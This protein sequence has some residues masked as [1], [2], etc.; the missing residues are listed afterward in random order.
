M[1][2]L[3]SLLNAADRDELTA[4]LAERV[5]FDRVLAPLTWWQVGGPA[6]AYAD[7]HSE[8]ELGQVLT[9]CRRRSMPY[10]VLGNGSNILVGDGGIRGLVL[11]LGGEFTSIDITTSDTTV[12]VNAGGAASLALL[13][14]QAASRGAVGIDGLAGVPA[15]VGGAVRMNAGTEREIG[16][17]TREVFVQSLGHPEPASVFVEYHYR[18]S[19]LAADAIVSRVS[20]SFEAG[21]PAEVRSSLQTR[22]VRRKATQPVGQPNAGS[23]FRNPPGDRA[24]RLIEAVGAKGWRVGGA[25]VSTLHANFIVN[26]GG[27]TA[28]D[29]S[30]L[31]ARVRNAVLEASGIALELEVHFVG[32]FTAS[33][34]TEVAAV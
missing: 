24:G 32:A 26:T 3:A 30:T 4:L 22:L 25:E 2:E 1:S 20:M 8:T 34:A 28:Q 10:F 6:D 5:T 15:T 21:D 29:V 11:R 16:E 9:F 7:V 23:C 17:F 12:T 19:S 27:A 18:R 14:G 33:D 13:T 31:L